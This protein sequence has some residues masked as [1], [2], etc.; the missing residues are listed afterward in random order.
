M[1]IASAP[2]V[3]LEISHAPLSVPQVG[4][5]GTALLSYK[6]INYSTIVI[7]R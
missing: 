6:L 3:P 5:L 2:G 7:Y 4:R 1:V